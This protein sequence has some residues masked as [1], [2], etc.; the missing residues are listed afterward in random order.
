[1]LKV[2]L[3]DDVTLDEEVFV[4]TQTMLLS[5]EVGNILIDQSRA[6]E[7]GENGCWIDKSGSV[8]TE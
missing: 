1:M 6:A 5:D 7:T 8:I 3:A 4:A 2:I